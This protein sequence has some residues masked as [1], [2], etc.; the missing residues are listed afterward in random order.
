[1]PLLWSHAEFL[2]LLIAREHGQP[3][4]LLQAV[5]QRYDGK[6]SRDAPAW[7]WRHEVPIWR[8]E[9]GR[10]LRIQDRQP[11]TL[12]FGFDGWKEVQDRE[13]LAG[14]FGLWTV[15]LTAA[16]LEPH[17]AVDFTRRYGD[18]WEEADHRVQLGHIDIEHALTHV[19]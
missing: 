5:A 8:L 11:F 14:P 19:D 9:A 10:A 15:Q 12:H 1:M 4:E 13:A 2:K 3:V 7:H 17:D 6:V 18:N 16:E